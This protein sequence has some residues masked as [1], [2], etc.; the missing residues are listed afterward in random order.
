MISTDDSTT[1]LELLPE[2]FEHLSP[3]E[4]FKRMEIPSNEGIHTGGVWESADGENVWK[5]WTGDRTGCPL[6]EESQ[7]EK[8]K[9]LNDGGSSGVSQNWRVKYVREEDG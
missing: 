5:P 7:P 6:R 2:W 8:H 9:C 1:E 4:G 3:G